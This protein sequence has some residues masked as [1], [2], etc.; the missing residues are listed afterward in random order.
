MH[1]RIVI[2]LG[3]MTIDGDCTQMTTPNSQVI[4]LDYNAT[5]PLREEVITRM[6]EILPVTG[7]ASSVHAAGRQARASVEHAREAI[8]AMAGANTEHVIFTGGATEANNTILKSFDGPSI[9]ISAIEH[10]CV[11]GSAPAGHHIVPVDAHGIIDIGALEQT[12]AQ[13][14]APA[15]VSVMLVNNETGVIQPLSEIVQ[16]ARHYGAYIHTD[17]AQAAGRL[18]LDFAQWGIDYMSLS[19]HKFGGPQ[20][21]GALIARGDVPLKRYMDGGG[22]ERSKRAGTENT[23]AIAGFGKAAELAQAGIDDMPRLQEMR[24]RLERDIAA[25][26]NAARIYGTDVPRVANTSV[27]GLPRLPAETQLMRLDL[28]GI[29]VSSGSACS[30]GAV[31]PSHVLKAMG[32]NDDEAGA[33]IRVSLGWATQQGDIDAF[34]GAWRKMYDTVKD[35]L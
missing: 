23:A 20:G 34:L 33:A 24:D 25:I 13:L 29:C 35:R 3:I 18:P 10:D 8:A 14:E 4:Y 11:R 26:S 21:V 15:L 2:A 17:A 31:R 12:L 22:Q 5:T 28:D 27:I 19:A 32:A 6:Q 9:A 30:S 16:L 1:S 7:N